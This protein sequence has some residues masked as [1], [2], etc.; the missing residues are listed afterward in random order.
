M[1]DLT[2]HTM[3]GFRERPEAGPSRGEADC[4]RL[5][6]SW[7]SP[8]RGTSSW[9]SC[10]GNRLESG[11]SLAGSGWPHPHPLVREKRLD[12]LGQLGLGDVRMP[13]FLASGR[14]QIPLT[15]WASVSS[16]EL[17]ASNTFCPRP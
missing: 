8:W 13:P 9:R 2:A 14:E 17:G 11:D 10:L 4:G 3:E 6:G 1:E 5:D 16:S 7:E 12:Q 15:S